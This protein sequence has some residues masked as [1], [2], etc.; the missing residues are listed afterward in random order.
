MWSSIISPKRFIMAV[1]LNRSIRVGTSKTPL[2][3]AMMAT[4]REALSEYSYQRR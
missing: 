4:I 3:M 2:S 1:R